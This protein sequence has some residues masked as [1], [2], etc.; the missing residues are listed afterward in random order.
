[1]KNF[2]WILI[3]L[4][5]GLAGVLLL[6]PEPARDAPDSAPTVERIFI[7]GARVFD[8]ETF[9]DDATLVIAEGQVEAL[10][11]NLV[12]D[13]G[14][15]AV[16]VS[17]KTIL[18]G[19]IDAHVHSF[20][21]AR[22]DALRFGVT[23]MLDMFRP[24]LDF[25]RTH[26]ERELLA[27]TDQADLYSAGFLA[28]APGG[29]G[30]QYGIEV[31]TLSGPEQAAAWVAA[32]KAEG[33]DWIKIV[34]EPG[35]GERELP[36][37]DAATV[38]ALAEA[39]HAAGLMAVAHVSTYADAIAAIEAGVDGL[40][41]LFGDQRVDEA[42]ITTAREA[43]IFVVP[44]TPVLAAAWGHDDTEWLLDHPV[45]GA[46]LSE[47]QRHNLKARFPGANADSDGWATLLHNIEA[48]QRAG[49]PIL[50]GSDA[51]NPGT[52][53]GA[54]MHH[55]LRLLVEAGLT[56]I[57][58]LR[59]ATSRPAQAFGLDRRGCLKPGCRADLVIVNGN[60]AS[61]IEATA[62]IEAVWKNGQP[63]ATAR[64]AADVAEPASTQVEGPIDLLAA[65]DRWMAAA[66]DYMGGQ[67]S[68]VLAWETTGLAQVTGRVADG[69]MFPYAG[70]M[71]FASATPMQPVDHANYRRLQ[72]EVQGDDVDYSV[73]FF[74]G[75]SQSARPAQVPI[76]AGRVV[77]IELDSVGGLDPKRLR[78]I[79]IFA[80]GQDHAV[81]FSIH[82]ARLE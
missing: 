58:A 45:L 16:D 39:A 1:M 68:A 44:T 55:A 48:L 73:M 64:P 51:P 20:G 10:G 3:L 23:T 7:T 26:A 40:V 18:P 72:V 27:P 47:A 5:A 36:R 78:A 52:T 29:H 67:S 2:T 17:G 15:E 57:D 35:W 60:P 37:L 76:K 43:D 53:Y 63:V 14:A 30:T 32:R 46:R 41:H 75:E 34:I 81:D 42:F 33:S 9:I 59:A 25:E 56:P 12:V 54:S 50:A 28:T 4:I 22:A 13:D 62:R 31:P 74:S 49:V 24:P 19:L 61:D 79:G 38:A 77:T 6:L 70:A 69:Y 65:P 8:G 82:Q 80:G 66:D 71:W 21:T 11:R